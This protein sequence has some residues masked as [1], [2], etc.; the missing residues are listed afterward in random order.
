MKVSGTLTFRAKGQLVC[1]RTAT[2][3]G[4]SIAGEPLEVANSRSLCADGARARSSPTVRLLHHRHLS[5][6]WRVQC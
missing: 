5:S 6:P 3:S 2:P 4:R 1:G